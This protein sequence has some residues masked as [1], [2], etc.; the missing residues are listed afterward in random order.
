MTD[1]EG[2]AIQADSYAQFQRLR[3]ANVARNKLWDPDNKLAALWRGN[4]LAGELG[5][6]I[7]VCNTIKK[8]EREALGL[9]GSRTTLDALAGELADMVICTDL[10]AMQFNIP[11][12]DAVR[13]KFNQTS[14]AQKFNVFL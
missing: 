10:T 7:V 11:L 9:P 6:L 3:N 13:Q 14:E 2:L 5:E 8:L 12:W 1:R 4:E